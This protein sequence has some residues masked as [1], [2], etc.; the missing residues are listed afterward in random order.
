[1]FDKK[2]LPNALTILRLMLLPALWALAL[3]GM[4]VLVGI[5]IAFAWLTDALDG[6][7]ARRFD[8]STP[9]GSR[10]D[11]VA[12]GLLAVSIAVWLFMLR[13]EF[14][15]EHALL[16]LIWLALGA[17]SWLV[18]WIRFRRIADLHLYS[19]KAANFLGFFFAAFLFA[20]DGY[21][22][23][24]FYFVI[25]VCILA[26]L[27]TLLALLTRDRVDERMTTILTRFAEGK[28]R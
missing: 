13:P 11:S 3:R 22:R 28:R 17:A 27:E 25:G 19:A 10:L 18:G 16:I 4:D 24:L 23:V 12:D 1:M 8:A 6:F 20:F 9:L 26:A 2:H 5:G 21:P 15:R 14:F 7:L